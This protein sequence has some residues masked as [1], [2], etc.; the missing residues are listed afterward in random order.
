MRRTGNQVARLVTGRLTAWLVIVLGLAGA[1]ALIALAPEA[2][3]TDDATAGLPDSVQS[4]I[5]AE[6]QQQ[7]PS[8]ELNPALVVYSRPGGT[9]TSADLEAIT[10]QGPELAEIALGG[11]VSPPQPAPDGAAAIVAVPL[12][13][14]ATGEETVADVERIRQTVRADLPAGVVAQVTGGAGFVADLNSAFAGADVRLLATTAAVVAVLLLITYR[15]PLLWIVPLVVVA[16]ADRATVALIAIASQVTDLP[17]NAST[18]GIVSVLV[19]GAGTDYALLL[20]AR[21]REELRRTPD[22]RAAMRAAWRGA[23]PAIAASA[24]TVILALLTLLLANV[25]GTQAIG[26]GGAIGI[27]TALLFG[28][29]VLPAALVVFPR[30][31]FWPLVP[32]VDAD[33]PDRKQPGRG[34]RRIGLATAR[35][36]IWVTLGSVLVLAGLSLGTTTTGFGLSQADT[37]RT[38]AESVDGLKTISASYPAGVVSP[39]V[40]MTTPEAADAVAETVQDV[41]G[42]SEVR[43]GERTADIA[44]LSVVIAAAPDTAESY[45]TIRDLR[46]A[47]VADDPG[48][49]VG[50]SVAT[51]LDARNTSIRDLTLISPL[52]LA[53]VLLVLV[54]LLR[55]LVAPLVLI[56]TVILSFFAALGAGS[57]LFSYVLDFPALDYQVPLLSFLFL[58][59]LG[60]DYNIFLVSRAREETPALGTRAA[61]VEALAVT[62]GVITSAGVLLAAVFTVLGVLPVIVLTEIGVIVGVGVLLDTLLVRT[63]LVPALV[64]L[65]GDR[66]WWPGRLARTRA[67]SAPSNRSVATPM[68]ARKMSDVTGLSEDEAEDEAAEPQPDPRRARA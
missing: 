19:F 24:A 17:F 64:T 59:A 11:R 66:F 42:V 29:V 20:I 36:P 55:A 21:Y 63:V 33:E 9:L 65:L 32:R 43:P 48:A 16:L 4:T 62:G 68:R 58:V 26:L 54:I 18:A 44:E 22:R 8:G 3:N 23:G 61:I 60:V 45:Q 67:P 15:S 57:L 31:L 46:A 28:L 53:V 39:V 6:R 25:G 35:R 2:R 12:S 51:N 41:A 37:F 10:A 56:G 7:L 27:A 1:A 34:W 40:V 30:G 50:G 38:E 47:V 5:A 14:D 49:V 13:G 52:I